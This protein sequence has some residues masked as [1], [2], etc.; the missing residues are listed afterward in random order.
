MGA[1]ADMLAQPP[2]PAIITRPPKG[3]EP[4]VHDTGDRITITTDPLEA[5][6]DPQVWAELVADWGID[7]D[8]Y[9][10]VPGTM[11]FRGWDAAVGNG[12]V[13]R[14]RYY[15]VTLVERPQQGQ[16]A[17]VDELC[18]MAAKRKP[19]RAGVVETT[20]P[21]AVIS[22]N[23][24]QLGKGEGGGTEATV[25]H[26][27]GSFD[28]WRQHRRWLAKT[29]RRPSSA[30]IANTG[31]LTERVQGHY[32]SQ[33]FTVDLNDR[34]QQKVARSLLMRLVDDAVDDGYPALVTAVPCNHGENRNG[35]GK[36]ITTADDNMSLILVESIEEACRANPDRYVAVSFAYAADHVLAVPIAGV[37]VAMTHG[38]QIGS[39]RRRASTTATGA[40]VV[41]KWWADQA[42]GDRENVMAHADILLTAHRHHLQ[43]SEETGRLV[44][45][46]PA[47]DGGSYWYTSRTGRQS[48]RGV[49]TLTIGDDHPRGWGDLVIL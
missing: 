20:N 3:W 37:N 17:D 15:R 26:L 19:A 25:D 34:E 41:E 12:N 31:D 49:L 27:V 1:L 10:I 45:V 18:S 7:P 5:E 38:H 47:A 33:P 28:A 23:D 32:P 29:G 35:N 39:G 42:F 13:Q 16:R 36:A 22:A 46:A 2:R 11:Q 44:I 30:V 8:R 40:A 48:T 21:A 9:V 4:G 24:W 43:I 6:P 14:L